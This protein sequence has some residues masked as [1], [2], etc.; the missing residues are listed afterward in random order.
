MI[1]DLGALSRESNLLK[2]SALSPPPWRVV[3]GGQTRTS[4]RR[5]RSSTFD[6]TAASLLP[7]WAFVRAG[8]IVKDSLA[9]RVDHMPYGAERDFATRSGRWSSR[10]P[11][12]GT[13][14]QLIVAWSYELQNPDDQLAWCVQCTASKGE[15]VNN[16]RVARCILNSFEEW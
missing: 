9:Y 16:S 11:A 15:V 5:S 6:H 1:T 14:P 7:T 12:G 10:R 13:G 8:L 2:M 4:A 3:R